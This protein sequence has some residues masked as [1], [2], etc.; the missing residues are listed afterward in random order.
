MFRP[1]T[2]VHVLG[3]WHINMECDDEGSDEDFQFD[4]GPRYVVPS[5]YQEL[6]SS[7]NLAPGSGNDDDGWKS[8]DETCLP[9]VTPQKGK[10]SLPL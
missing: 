3:L 2:V 4:S 10:S 1:R 5:Y 7:T 8:D 6:Y 9:V